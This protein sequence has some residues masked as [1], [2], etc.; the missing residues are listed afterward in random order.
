MRKAKFYTESDNVLDISGTIEGKEVVFA[1]P[2]GD[3]KFVEVES[4]KEKK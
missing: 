4:L 3:G 2:I 1:G